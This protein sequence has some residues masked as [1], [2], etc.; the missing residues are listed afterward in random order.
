[1]TTL[2]SSTPPADVCGSEANQAPWNV[3]HKNQ[4]STTTHPHYFLRLIADAVNEESLAEKGPLMDAR[5]FYTETGFCAHPETSLVDDQ[6]SGDEV[7]GIC[8]L[9][10][11][12]RTLRES[13]EERILTASLFPWEDTIGEICHM[14]GVGNYSCIIFSC[15]LHYE[16][17]CKRLPAKTTLGSSRNRPNR[18]FAAYAFFWALHDHEVYRPINY[19][20]DVFSISPAAILKAEDEI[21]KALQKRPIYIS[22]MKVMISIADKVPGLTPSLRKA[23]IHFTN[24]VQDQVYGASPERVVYSILYHFNL[25]LQRMKDERKIDMNTVMDLFLFRTKPPVIPFTQFDM[26]ELFTDAQEKRE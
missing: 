26:H 17:I 7:C 2:P 18:A 16:S 14:L 25:Y 9:V 8:G 21:C 4:A 5:T 1:M 24:R 11:A 23:L 3:T 6:H 19:I 15:R 12:E 20:S 13:H 10:L 22:P